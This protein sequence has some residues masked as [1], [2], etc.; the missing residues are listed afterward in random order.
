[1]I[2]VSEVPVDNPYFYSSRWRNTLIPRI[3]QV[4]MLDRTNSNK[5]K[6]RERLVGSRAEV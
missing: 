4:A 6:T 3:F 5:S 1:L 2:S